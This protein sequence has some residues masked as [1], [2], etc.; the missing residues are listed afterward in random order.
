MHADLWCVP[1]QLLQ[2]NALAMENGKTSHEL[3]EQTASLVGLRLPKM[4]LEAA[5]AQL[6]T[7]KSKTK[8]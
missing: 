5:D 3:L 1:Q 2:E 4:D 8:K 6:S 7:A